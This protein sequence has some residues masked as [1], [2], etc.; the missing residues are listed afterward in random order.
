MCIIVTTIHKSRSTNGRRFAKWSVY[1]GWLYPA[2]AIFKWMSTDEYQA[3]FFV[4][5]LKM[6][7]NIWYSA[8][9]VHVWTMQTCPKFQKHERARNDLQHDLMNVSFFFMEWMC[10]LM[11]QLLTV[12]IST[13]F[14][15]FPFH[16]IWF[17]HALDMLVTLA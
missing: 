15:L 10:F 12:S 5:D 3:A 9:N 7:I 16:N 4:H 6:V 1:Y 11:Y 13:F 14:T 2:L 17:T 8:W